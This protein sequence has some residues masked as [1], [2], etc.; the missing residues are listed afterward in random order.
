MPRW[1]AA[2]GL[3]LGTGVA[4]FFWTG[5]SGPADTEGETPALAAPALRLPDIGGTERALGDWAGAVRV[6][7]FWASWCEP[8]RREMP[9]LTRLQKRHGPEGI[10][11]IGIAL[12]DAAQVAAFLREAGLESNYPQLVAPGPAGLE[13]A[14][15][16]NNPAG[17]LPY[18]VFVDRDGRIAHRHFGELTYEEAVALALAAR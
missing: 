6:V 9:A 4:A 3:V 7:N 1:L 14:A 11:V 17:V 10:Q 15:A 13:L 8:C 16:W 2:A 18:T 5:L 12:D